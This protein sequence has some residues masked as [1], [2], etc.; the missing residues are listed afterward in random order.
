M[1][2]WTLGAVSVFVVLVISS[3]GLTV[4]ETPSPTPPT[5]TQKAADNLLDLIDEL[6]PEDEDIVVVPLTRSDG[7]SLQLVW[8]RTGVKAHYHARHT[9]TVVILRGRGRFRIGEDTYDAAPGDAFLIPPGAVHAFVVTEDGPVAA[10]TT[11]SP[12]FDGEDRVFVEE[13]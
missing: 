2:P 8:I 9:E 10:V 5:I 11:F 13:P 4:G 6:P 12:A 7:V 1:R 3:P